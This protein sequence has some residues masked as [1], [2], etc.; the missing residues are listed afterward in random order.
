VLPASKIPADWLHGYPAGPRGR[1]PV[2]LNERTWTNSSD[3]TFDTLISA[4]H[5]SDSESDG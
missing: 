3:W 5:P 1:L 4:W 2:P